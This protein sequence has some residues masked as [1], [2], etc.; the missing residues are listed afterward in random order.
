MTRMHRRWHLALWVVIAPLL[1]AGLTA[2]ILLR[3]R[4]ANSSTPGIPA[5]EATP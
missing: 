1:L 2:G 4:L 3:P 5:R